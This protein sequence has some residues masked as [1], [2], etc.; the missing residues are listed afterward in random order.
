MSSSKNQ[1]YTDAVNEE[2]YPA[3]RLV[4]LDDIFKDARGEINNLLLNQITSVARITS[5]K[6]TVRANHYHLT[7]WHYAFLEVGRILYFEREVGSE[8]VP[9]PVV[10]EPGVMFFTPP[11]VEHAMVFTEDS[12]FF[13]F[14]K[15]VR[16]H[17][18][19]E[20][21]LVRVPFISEDVL[22]KYL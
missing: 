15:N 13:T 7:D 10:I 12:V 4:P 19:H 9:D 11:N 20:Q 16:S 6:G 2:V 8:V 18:N 1:A 14:A 21:D 22:K 5:K 3:N 17:E